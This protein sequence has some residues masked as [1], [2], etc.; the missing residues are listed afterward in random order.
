MKEQSITAAFLCVCSFRAHLCGG[1]QRQRASE[2]GKGGA[3]QDAR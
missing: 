3:P 1:Q 2:R